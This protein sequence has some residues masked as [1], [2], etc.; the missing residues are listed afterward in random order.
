MIHSCF[1]PKT[2]SCY[3]F[4]V[5]IFQIGSNDMRITKLHNF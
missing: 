2:D 3:N 4:L 5:R 1:N